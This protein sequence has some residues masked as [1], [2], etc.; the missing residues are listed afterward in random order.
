MAEE[1]D[2]MVCIRPARAQH[3]MPPTAGDV[4]DETDAD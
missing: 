2:D 4:A 1:K 3:T